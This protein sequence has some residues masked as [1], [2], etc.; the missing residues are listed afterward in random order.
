MNR[1]AIIAT[2]I[3]FAIGLLITGMIIVAPNLGKWLP[4]LSLPTLKLAWPRTGPAVSPTPTPP[5]T[6]LTIA[7][8]LPEAIENQ[9]ELLVSG[10]APAGA[11]VIIGGPL[12]E[13]VAPAGD[14]GKFAATVSLVEGKNDLT[15]TSLLSDKQQTQTLTVYYTP[16]E[17]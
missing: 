6:S 3:G 1:D 2:L 10:T 11:L 4:K 12:D 8:P 13:A 16:E 7:A 14:E 17:F 9:A 5:A 15:V